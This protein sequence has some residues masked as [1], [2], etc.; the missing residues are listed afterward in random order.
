MAKQTTSHKALFPTVTF[1]AFFSR[2]AEHKKWDVPDFHWRMCDWLEDMYR[3][4]DPQART[5]VEMV[6]RGG[7]K[8]TL[9]GAFIAYVLRDDPE[10]HFLILSADDT[11]AWKMSYDAQHVI[12]THPWCQGLKGATKLWQTIRWSVSGNTDRRNASVSSHGIMSNITSSRADMV[13]F[14]DVEVPKNCKTQLLREEL[15]MRIDETTHILVPGGKK[16]FVG[17]PHTFDTIYVEEI[18]KGANHLIIP[19]INDAGENA[20]P[21]RF[22]DEEVA[23]RQKECKTTAAWSS[24]YLL[25]PM[26]IHDIRLDPMD[27]VIY[28]DNPVIRQANGSIAM[29][30]K[31]ADGVDVQII[32]ASA[33][34][35]VSMGK[36]NSD[37]SVL[38][39]VLTDASGNLYWQLADCLPGGID[40]QCA[41]VI[42]RIQ[43]FQIPRLEIETNGPGGFVPAILRK[44]LSSAGLRCGIIEKYQNGNKQKRILDAFEAP[45]SGRLLYCHQELMNGTMPS[46][47]REWTPEN[48]SWRTHDDILDA[49]AGAISSTPVRIGNAVSSAMGF[50]DWR[51]GTGTR[52]ADFSAAA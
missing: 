21:D 13:I 28:Y 47:M 4:D 9:L 3:S 38:A 43:Q 44:H 48:T 51:P 26:P 29:W 22:T 16:L 10:Y 41:F 20:W 50:V 35:D 19:L 8:S 52:L 24:Q 23:H 42:K 27:L 12:E 37:D 7:S 32:G 2:W 40:E 1:R 30:L 49:G 5:N 25:K 39:L 46:Q 15:R 36:I 6:F 18:N 34:W 14:D 11:T 17:T 45:L 31:R 33:Y